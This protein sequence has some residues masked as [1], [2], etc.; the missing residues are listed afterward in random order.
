MDVVIR[1]INP[2]GQ[3]GCFI[4][5]TND[6]ASALR[7]EDAAQVFLMAD[8]NGV[9]FYRKFESEN[10]GTFTRIS[11]AENDQYTLS[12]VRFTGQTYA[13]INGQFAGQFTEVIE[14]PFQLVYGAA[15][16]KEGDT[17]SCSFDNLSVRKVNMQ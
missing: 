8:K 9:G 13:Y 15:A 6:L 11:G 7:H 10:S 2:A 16:L 12:I 3:A 1:D 17:A 14:G 5:Y 4:G